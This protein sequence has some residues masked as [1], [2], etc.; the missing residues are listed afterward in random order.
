M[1]HLAPPLVALSGLLT[2][3]DVVETQF[4]GRRFAHSRDAGGTA[5]HRASLHDSIRL[6]GQCLKVGRRRTSEDS[7][8]FHGQLSKEESTEEGVGIGIEGLH[9][10]EE[11]RR[12]S[13]P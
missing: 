13:I 4:L 9:V 10:A 5:T 2:K 7:T 8:H 3:L 12:L 1:S 6:F 11:A